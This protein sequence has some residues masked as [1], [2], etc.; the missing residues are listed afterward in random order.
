MYISPQHPPALGQSSPFFW[1]TGDS[2]YLDGQV[3]GL[4]VRLSNLKLKV[5]AQGLG[6]SVRFSTRPAAAFAAQQQSLK[7]AP[8]VAEN[9]MAHV[10]EDI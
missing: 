2:R 3:S 6:F 5:R 1:V 10:R 7:D 9:P 8:H 4:A